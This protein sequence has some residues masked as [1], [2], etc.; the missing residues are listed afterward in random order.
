MY[1]V[2]TIFLPTETAPTGMHIEAFRKFVSDHP[3]VKSKHMTTSQISSIII[4]PETLETNQPYI[5]H[6]IGTK[7]DTSSRKREL[8]GPS[9]VFVSHAWRYPFCDVVL[10]VL[11]Q[12]A[13]EHPDSYFWF[14]LFTNNQ[15]EV[16][17][18][19][20]DWFS[21]TFKDG[22]RNIGQ[23][24][25]IL[26][27]WDDPLPLRRA[28]CLFE[29]FNSI[30]DDDVE[31]S[32]NL[33]SSEVNKLKSAVTDDC[34]CLIQ[35]LSDIQAENADAFV[36]ADKAMIFEVIR[37]S[38]GGF[39]HVNEKVK[40]GLRDW[41]IKQ[42]EKL[43]DD[44][45]EDHDLKLTLATIMQEF[46]FIDEALTYALR[47]Q[48]ITNADEHFQAELNN[49]LANLY[50]DKGELDKALQFHE[51]SLALSLGIHGSENH[52][53]VA[54]SYNNMATVF[55]DKGDLDKSLEY[56]NKALTITKKT[57]GQNHAK[58]ASSYNNMANVYRSK[59]HL[60]KALEYYDMSLAIDLTTYGENHPEVAAT[61]NNMANV[62]SDKG[63]IEKSLDSH[64]KALTIRLA[65]L[66][67]HHLDVAESYNNMATVYRDSGEHEKALEYYDKSLA[68]TLK[69]HGEKHSDVAGLYNNMANVYSDTG[70]L[71]KALEYHGMSLVIRIAILGE[72]H[73]IIAQ[74]HQ[75]MAIVYKSKGDLDMALKYYNNSLLVKIGVL[76]DSHPE[77]AI[78]YNQIASVYKAKGDLNTAL[79]YY[80]KALEIRV[81]TFGNKH[82]S[83]ADMHH[84]IGL[85]HE[86]MADSETA[87]VSM[88][89]ALDIRQQK[90]GEDHPDVI[91]TQ[92]I[93]GR[94]KTKL[95]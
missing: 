50:S 10:D 87:M 77:V 55:S 61:Y 48:S 11:E 17:S 13:K 85:V 12:H 32:I 53:D 82:H 75:N 21:T 31:L 14:D 79:D 43:V 15:N 45:P 65:T 19:D 38:T 7:S 20:F 18:K 52:E 70:N 25:L 23:V 68:I 34:D 1:K 74:S 86:I 67:H 58:V 73:P 90:H 89:K 63:E 76:G 64:N 93:I 81:E 39:A 92:Q 5:N 29:I 56:H 72:N 30:V 24:L 54:A 8:T 9:T 36:S 84:N 3:E 22:V 37:K 91:E 51:Q 59:G 57:L 71:N 44:S 40:R 28:W 2:T 26:S 6:Y 95:E 80:K 94:L 88:K 42:L 33:P 4:K 66:G 49:A 27:P 78:L 47:C 60:E 41:Y 35:A 83:V 16:A 69:M 46:G 62:F